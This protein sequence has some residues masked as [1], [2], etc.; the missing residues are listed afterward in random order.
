MTLLLL[1]GM[2]IVRFTTVPLIDQIKYEWDV[3]VV[4]KINHF[5]YGFSFQREDFWISFEAAMKENAK[6]KHFLNYRNIFHLP[7]KCL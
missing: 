1:N 2:S 5:M 4:L 3:H 7:D 6:I